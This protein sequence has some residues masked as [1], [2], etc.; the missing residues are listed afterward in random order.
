MFLPTII[1]KPILTLFHGAVRVNLLLRPRDY[2]YVFV[3]AHMRSG[4]TLLSHI[5]VSHPD[6]DGAGETHTFYKAPEDLGRLVPRTCELLR[7]LQVTSKYVVDKITMDQYLSDEVLALLPIHK[8]IILFRKPEAALKSIIEFFKWPQEMALDH[9]VTRLATLA[10]YGRV[11]RDRA[12][13]VEYDALVDQ[14]QETLAALTRFFD[15]DQ[16][17]RQAYTKTKVTGK[18]GDPS[19]NIL[20]GKIVRTPEHNLQ[21]KTDV[22]TEAIRAVQNCRLDLLSAGVVPATDDVFHGLDV[23][24]G[25]P[26]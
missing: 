9:Y 20:T 2:Q 22:M 3:L 14:P 5:L 26:A 24:V 10:L 12:I 23:R 25:R 13:C 8:S 19:R 18:M 7:K 16:P 15:V 4:S 11:L 17:F 6:F 1:R 21:I